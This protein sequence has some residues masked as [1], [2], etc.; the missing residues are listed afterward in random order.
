MGVAA[1]GDF[2]ECTDCHTTT[3]WDTHTF[4]HAT[5]AFPLTGRHQRVGCPQCHVDLTEGYAPAGP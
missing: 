2:G 1:H 5:V 4:D 3:G